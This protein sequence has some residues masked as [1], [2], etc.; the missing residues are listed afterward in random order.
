MLT[1]VE[2]KKEISTAI[3]DND[4]TVGILLHFKK[5]DIEHGLLLKRYGN[6]WAAHSRLSSYLKKILKYLQINIKPNQGEIV[7][8]KL[9]CKRCIHLVKDK[10]SRKKTRTSS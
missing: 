6:R 1:L 4:H 9:G 7:D 8:N 5:V 10:V 3:E 2:L